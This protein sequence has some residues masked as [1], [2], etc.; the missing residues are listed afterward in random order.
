MSIENRIPDSPS[1]AD[2]LRPRG[3]VQLMLTRHD[4]DGRAI[5]AAAGELDLLTAPQFNAEVDDCLRHGTG[6]LTIDARALRFVDSAG[7]FVLLN[8][9]RRLTR[10]GRR[11]RVV[12]SEGP[13]LRTIQLARLTETL[14]VE[15]A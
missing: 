10:Q 2:E 7:L 1:L 11:L 12:C 3:P 4:G 6:D 15:L 14:G 8:L 9:Q 5:V 13:V